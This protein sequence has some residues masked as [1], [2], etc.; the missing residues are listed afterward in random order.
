[1]PSNPHADARPMSLDLGS[2][3][4]PLPFPLDECGEVGGLGFWLSR[5]LCEFLERGER[6]RRVIIFFRWKRACD[7]GG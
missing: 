3:L 2:A 4:A 6:A 5:D 1:M 7:G